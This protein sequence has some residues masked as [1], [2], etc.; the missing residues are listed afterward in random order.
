M[1]GEIR[2]KETAAIA[3]QAAQTGHIVLATV[4]TNN[5]LETINR[6]QSI[7]VDCYQLISCVSLIIAQRLVRKLC[8]ACK[9]QH[10]FFLTIQ[11]IY[12]KQIM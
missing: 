8:N 10:L 2:D 12:H 1:I 11:P 7:G 5:A 9:Q 6:L 4:H 3:I